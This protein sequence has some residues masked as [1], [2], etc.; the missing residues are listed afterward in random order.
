MPKVIFLILLLTTYHFFVSVWVVGICTCKSVCSVCTSDVRALN[1]ER[2]AI[3]Y[4]EIWKHS[5]DQSCKRKKANLVILL[6]ALIR[7]YKRVIW[8][9]LSHALAKAEQI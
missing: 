7:S 2:S 4:R 3:I 8:N 1:T 5:E 6:Q 9:Q